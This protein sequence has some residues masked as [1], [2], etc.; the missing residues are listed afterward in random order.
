M[1]PEESGNNGQ[2][3]SVEV[4]DQKTP[5]EL[6]NRCSRIMELRGKLGYEA[7]ESGSTWV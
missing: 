7:T 1:E 2:G 5:V 3:I 6:S 4:I